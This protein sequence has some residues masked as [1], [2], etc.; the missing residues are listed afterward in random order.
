MSALYPFT[1]KSFDIN[2]LTM[3]YLDEGTGP[4]IVMLHGNPTWSFYYR[5]LVL[6][7]RAEFRVIVPDHMGCGLS[8]K[9]QDYPYTLET[10]INNLAALV[11]HLGLC[12]MSLMVHDWGGA[13][14]MGF[15]G[16]HP[17]IIRSLVI[18]N[19]AAFCSSRIPWRIWLCRLPWLGA[20]LVRGLNGF[21]R[22]AVTMAVARKLP[23]E[24]SHG[25]LAPYNSW[26]NRVAIYSFVR[27]IPLDKSHVSWSVLQSIE[28]NLTKLRSKP[29]LILWGGRDF[30]F[31][32][33][34]YAEWLKRFPEARRHYFAGAGHY[35]LEDAGDEIEPMVRDFFHE[36]QT[37][38]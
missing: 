4:V 5:N 14:G 8:A 12:D 31:D 38:G 9:P 28:E 26:R 22:P 6:A 21:A 20:L 37:D 33:V 34:F 16:R 7:L 32:N 17:K 23:C 27:D 24:V 18:T 1:P 2:G 29:M 19:T 11:N 15:A 13:I 35:L 25:Y 30:C 36:V 10:H 3:S